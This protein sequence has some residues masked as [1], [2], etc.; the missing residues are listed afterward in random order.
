MS[1][2]DIYLYMHCRVCYQDR[3][4]QSLEVG[5][6]HGEEPVLVIW[7]ARHDELVATFELK[8]P[9]KDATCDCCRKEKMQ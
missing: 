6:S 2:S 5:M 3:L 1:S 7:C 8:N 4:P 9:P